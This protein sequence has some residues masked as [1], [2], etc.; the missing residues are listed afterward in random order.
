VTLACSGTEIRF[1]KSM[2]EKRIKT[3]GSGIETI[4][5]ISAVSLCSQV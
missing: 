1:Q 3:L 2:E 4:N 5:K